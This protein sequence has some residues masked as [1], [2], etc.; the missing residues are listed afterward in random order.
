MGLNPRTPGSRPEPKTDT[1]PLSHP[2]VPIPWFLL[3]DG[4]HLLRLNR[5]VTTWRETD[6]FSVLTLQAL[7]VEDLS[8]LR[9]LEGLVISL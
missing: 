7:I 5:G 3:N 2:G 9:P 6:S 8:F 4:I 1:Q